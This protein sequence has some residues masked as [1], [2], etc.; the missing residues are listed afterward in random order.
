MGNGAS[1][2]VEETLSEWKDFDGIKFPTR[3]TT[4]KNGRKADDLTAVEVKVNRALKLADLEK[5]P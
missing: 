4:R 2:A 1:M 5:K 3:I